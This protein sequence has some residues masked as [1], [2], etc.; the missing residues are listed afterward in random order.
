MALG[1]S[2]ACA[3]GMWVHAAS[4]TSVNGANGSAVAQGQWDETVLEI[5]GGSREEGRRVRGW[6]G[7]VD[8]SGGGK[9]AGN[10]SKYLVDRYGFDPGMPHCPLS[11]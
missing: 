7:E 10:V 6:L 1:E 4:P 9:K 8:I 2:E 11:G 3:T 5:L